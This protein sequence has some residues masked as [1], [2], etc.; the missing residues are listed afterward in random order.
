MQGLSKKIIMI[1]KDFLKTFSKIFL[2]YFRNISPISIT[3][4][5]KK[6]A[7]VVHVIPFT[8]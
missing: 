7:G 4:E 2:K 8:P 3:K 6:Q 1:F 5:I